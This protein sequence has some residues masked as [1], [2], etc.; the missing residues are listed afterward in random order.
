MAHARPMPEPAPVM[1]TERSTR[2][3]Y[4][5]GGVPIRS[6]AGRVAAVVAFQPV[7]PVGGRWLVVAGLGVGV[8][9]DL[10]VLCLLVGARLVRSATAD[11]TG[12]GLGRRVRSIVASCCP[13]L[14][15]PLSRP[16]L[17]R[18]SR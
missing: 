15:P 18:G 11:G 7:D 14:L 17:R 13:W 1:S 3:A 12:I 4:P 5:A 8:G 16:A 9:H 2:I 10:G 6:G